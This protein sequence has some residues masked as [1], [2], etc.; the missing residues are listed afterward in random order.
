LLATSARPGVVH[1]WDVGAGRLARE[2]RRQR[3]SGFGSE[4]SFALLTYAPNDLAFSPDGRRLAYATDHGTVRLHDVEGGQDLLVLQ[5]FPHQTDRLFFSRDGRKLFAVDS[6]PRWHQWDATPLPDEVAFERLA[7]ARLSALA[8][9]EL[10][11]PEEVRQRL[12][13]DGTLNDA[14]RSVLLRWAD[15]MH[16]DPN[17]FNSAAWQVALLPGASADEYEKALRRAKVACGVEAD[18][19]NHENTRAAALYRVGRYD[20]A[21]ATLRRCVALRKEEGKE[22]D[23]ADRAF[24]ALACHQLGRAEEAREHLGWLREQKRKK[25]EA[26]GEYDFQALLAEAERLIG[27]SP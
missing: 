10:L 12:L 1:L 4:G 21:L 8:G 6:Y 25:T 7:A 3:N 23:Y 20:E 5:D 26:A 14:A 17:R 19:P 27:D 13:D 2:I 15:T 11:T 9:D 18:N 24:L 16:V 22:P